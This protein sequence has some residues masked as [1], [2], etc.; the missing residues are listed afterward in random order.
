LN[1]DYS[2]RLLVQADYGK[3][4]YPRPIYYRCDRKR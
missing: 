4:Q 3:G 1:S 2:D